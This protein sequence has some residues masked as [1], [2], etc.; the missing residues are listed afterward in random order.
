MI[1]EKTGKEMVY[2][3]EGIFLYGE[4]KEERDLPGFWID[5][6]PVTNAE[7]QRFLDTHPDYPVP[8]SNEAWAQPYNWDRETRTFPAGREQ[9]PVGLVTWYD[10]EAYAAWAGGRPPSEEEW[11][12]AARGT[13]GRR[14]PWGAW[15]ENRC[16][17]AEAGLTT[18]TPVDAYSPAGDSPYG[19]VDMVGNVWE[20]A[21]TRNGLNWIVRGGSFISEKLYVRCTFRDWD[22][23]N[24]GIRLYGFRIVVCP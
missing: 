15:E 7:Y 24:S 23:P 18:T 13:D 22:L 9:H 14:Y 19:C 21:T 1:W 10:A 5:K 3:P 16:N 11:E 2:V 12:K 17:S 20:W 8:F 6:T 4:K